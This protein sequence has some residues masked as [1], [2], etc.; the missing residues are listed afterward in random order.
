MVDCIVALSLGFG[1]DILLALSIQHVSDILP[2]LSIAF[3]ELLILEASFPET[4][5]EFPEGT[6][7]PPIAAFV[8]PD[9]SWD[10]VGDEVAAGV[11]VRGGTVAVN[12]GRGSGKGD[13]LV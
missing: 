2:V 6:L 11:V 7:E 3:F 4:F 10:K 5:R 13:N 1:L 12:V 8:G 9:T